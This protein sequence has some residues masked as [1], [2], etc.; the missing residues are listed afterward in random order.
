MV[1]Y[2]YGYHCYTH[3]PDVDGVEIKG[4][5]RVSIRNTGL[6]ALQAPTVR[7]A[8][9]M[10][11]VNNMAFGLPAHR[12]VAV[13]PS[14]IASDEPIAYAVLIKSATLALE[15][16]MASL[17]EAEATRAL[18]LPFR[19]K[20]VSN[21]EDD[22]RRILQATTCINLNLDSPLDDDDCFFHSKPQPSR[23]STWL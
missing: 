14:S 1:C 8:Q 10:L 9:G 22:V 3:V 23:T 15:M 19:R 6:K 16:E 13:V 20:L 7:F 4:V 21:V 17:A 12:G 11:H 18:L 5:T 2:L